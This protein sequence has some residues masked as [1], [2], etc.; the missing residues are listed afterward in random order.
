[1]GRLLR[2]EILF[3]GCLTHKT[4]HSH[5]QDFNI[6][7]IEDKQKYLQILFQKIG[8]EIADI[9]AFTLMSNHIHEVYEIRSVGLFSDFMKVH[10]SMYGQYFNKKYDR[11]GKVANDRPHTQ[12]IAND[13]HEIISVLYCHANP[14]EA[15]I[16]K[17]AKNFEWSSH[18]FY[19]YGIDLFSNGK[20]V[21]PRWYA[22]LGS[23]FR[24]RQFHYLKIFDEYVENYVLPR[25]TQ[26]S[27][28]CVIVRADKP[29]K[30]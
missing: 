6:E 4:W 12:L 5:H 22:E 28:T 26:V 30:H 9:H 14:I 11:K 16:V 17:D 23:T 19:G 27:D 21:L 25:M 2:S 20:M 8:S 1:M 15:G 10:H 29:A 7:Q 24:D 13:V 3:D 18:L